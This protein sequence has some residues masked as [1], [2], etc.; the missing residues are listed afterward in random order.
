MN[1]D[2]DNRSFIQK[3]VRMYS[4]VNS[5]YGYVDIHKLV[6]MSSYKPVAIIEINYTLVNHC[7]PNVLLWLYS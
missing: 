3:Y 6:F 2:Q 7:K 5:W 4:I 1:K